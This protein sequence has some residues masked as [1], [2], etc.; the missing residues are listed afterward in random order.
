MVTTTAGIQFTK[1]Q[2]EEQL[3]KTITGLRLPFQVVE[4][5]AF[6]QLLNLVHSG[7]QRLDLPS[8]KTLRR[9]LRDAV[10]EQHASQLNDLP[11]GA[12]VSLALD[13]WTS[14]FQ[15]AFMAITAYFI[16]NE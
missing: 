12:K 5:G 15:Q 10:V 7:T 4:D 11:E 13:Y 2:L 8:A 1:E 16:D 3:L 6:Q 9:R 14:P